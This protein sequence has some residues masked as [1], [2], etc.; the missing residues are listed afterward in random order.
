MLTEVKNLHG[1]LDKK[2]ALCNK[3]NDHWKYK[4]F[5]LLKKVKATQ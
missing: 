5:Y 1:T 3:K 4:N 2:V